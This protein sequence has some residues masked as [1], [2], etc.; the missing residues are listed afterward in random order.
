MNDLTSAAVVRFGGEEYDTAGL[1][2]FAIQQ[3]ERRAGQGGIMIFATRQSYHD[4]Q[5][6]ISITWPG[7]EFDQSFDES[8]G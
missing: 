8:A 4:T 3:P 5:P 2:C 7:P 6:G 1:S